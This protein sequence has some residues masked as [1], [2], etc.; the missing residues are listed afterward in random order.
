MYGTF[1]LPV[2]YPGHFEYIGYISDAELGPITV[3]C[4][5][6][7]ASNYLGDI[8][9]VLDDFT[10]ITGTTITDK[11]TIYTYM[12]KN[13]SQTNVVTQNKISAA[14]VNTARSITLSY[15]EGLEVIKG[16]FKIEV[17]PG[18]FAQSEI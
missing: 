18:A 14:T 3:T 7:G 5:N 16:I 15:T 4:L 8:T 13:Y 9:W 6:G 17:Y 12:D 11:F 1:H 10:S 2:G